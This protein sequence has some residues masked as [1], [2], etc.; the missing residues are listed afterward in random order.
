[1]PFTDLQPTANQFYNIFCQSS[2]DC[3]PALAIAWYLDVLQCLF[4]IKAA[5]F[6]TLHQFKSSW[7]QPNLKTGVSCFRVLLKSST[8]LC[9]VF[10]VFWRFGGSIYQYSA[11]FGRINNIF[12]WALYLEPT[13]NNKCYWK[14]LLEWRLWKKPPQLS[15]CQA[16]GSCASPFYLTFGFLL[17]F[18]VFYSLLL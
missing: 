6:T 16:Q 4:V 5:F 18:G 14:A 10:K 9:V 15:L 1:M 17:Y 2:Q 3:F 12:K 13:Q 8:W 11:E 7:P